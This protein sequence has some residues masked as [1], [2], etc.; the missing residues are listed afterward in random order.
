MRVPEAYCFK[1]NLP[2]SCNVTYININLVRQYG[3]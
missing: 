1:N 2:E 3:D